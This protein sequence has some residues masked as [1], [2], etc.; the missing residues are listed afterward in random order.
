MFRAGQ[1]GVCLVVFCLQVSEGGSEPIGLSVKDLGFRISSTGRTQKACWKKKRFRI[2]SLELK[3]YR[4][5]CQ[6]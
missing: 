5:L 2:S 1:K 4:P 3:R 6:H